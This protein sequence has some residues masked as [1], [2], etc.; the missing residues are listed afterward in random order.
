MVAVIEW[1]SYGIIHWYTL[2]HNID[3]VM[4]DAF[5]TNRFG[6]VKILSRYNLPITGGMVDEG[7]YTVLL[8][9]QR[10]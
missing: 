9:A 7:P 8:Q 6:L 2:G 1:S 3:Q 10:L 4:E 5:R